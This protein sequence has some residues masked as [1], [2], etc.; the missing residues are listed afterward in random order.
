MRPLNLPAWKRWPALRLLLPFALGI[1]CQW[2][3]P[4]PVWTWALLLPLS[5]GL[6]FAL[7]RLPLRLSYRYSTLTG[8]AQQLLLFAFG[9]LALWQ[10]DI[11][12]HPHW[13]GNSNGPVIVHLVAPLTEKP[14]SWKAEAAVEQVYQHGR[15]QPARGTV[16]LYLRKEGPAPAWNYGTSLLVH[17]EP[18]P[19]RG[20]GNPG[21]FDYARYCLFQGITHQAFVSSAEV[22]ALSGQEGNALQGGLYAARARIVEILKRHIPGARERGLAEALLIG[23]KDDLDP[24]LVQAYTNT[25]V[26]HIIAISGM[27]LALVY[28]LLLGLTIPLRNKRLLRFLLVVAGLWLFSGMVGGS[29]SVLR[30]AVMFTLLA[31][32]Q[33]LGRE[34]A[35]M[36][37]LL[38]AALL[39]LAINPFWLW[40]V[41]FQLSFGAV[42]SIL[43]F[44]GPI[45]RALP[46]RN[47]ALDALWKLCAVSLAAQVLTTPLSLFHFHQ[48]PLLFLL[49]NL[50]AVPLS[51]LLVYALIAVCAASVWP[52]LAALVGAA[53]AAGMRLLNSWIDHLNGAPGAVWNGLS[54]SLAQ[55]LLLYA[56]LAAAA[57][58][59]AQRRKAFLWAAAGCALGVLGLRS[60]SFL[61][62]QQQRRIVVYNIAR[63]SALDLFEGRQHLFV[64]DAAAD[65]DPGLYRFHRQPAHVLYRSTAGTGEPG[66][67][68]TFGGQKILRL[69][70][71]GEGEAP[72]GARF[73]LV[74][75]AHS[76]KARP[77]ELLA[78][79]SVRRLVIDGSVPRYKAAL[80]KREAAARKIAVHD[81]SEQGAFVWDL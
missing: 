8:V 73:D 30:S 24:D 61:Q 76:P 43:L 32:G 44:Y 33:L 22:T 80:W 42:G 40:D 51:G 13:I 68:F 28:A 29:A 10:K 57:Y 46:L 67:A 5:G 16:L 49:A 70:G 66:A 35:S 41:G 77:E 60:L 75:L 3:L 36:N 52:D 78:A 59:I 45:Y 1:L 11:R 26:V 54:V 47:R 58:G 12:Q 17:K 56:L 38:L 21:A 34:G 63:H 69:D 23:Y 74:I 55:T 50:L 48:F 18:T 64:G 2:Y 14:G 20:S 81:V 27:H 7:P 39:L 9:A 79:C 6:L 62:A 25:G 19:V 72:A 53:A 15:W 37:S 31:V 65:S 4:A 71:A